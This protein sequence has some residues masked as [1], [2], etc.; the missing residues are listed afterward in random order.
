MCRQ[1]PFVAPLHSE[2]ASLPEWRSPIIDNTLDDAEL[3]RQCPLDDGRMASNVCYTLGVFEKLPVELLSMVYLYLDIPSL[4]TFRRVNQR[5]LLSV[6][7]LHE[8]RKVK[9]HCPNIL[10]AVISTEA[11]SY[12][13]RTLYRSLRSKTCV[14]CGRFGGYL[15]LLTSVRVCYSC[16]TQSRS[17]RPFAG[18][19]EITQ[20]YGLSEDDVARLPQLL[21]IPGTYT[22]YQVQYTKRKRLFDADAVRS[23]SM[24]VRKEDWDSGKLYGET[25]P[26]DAKHRTQLIRDAK[27]YLAIISAPH[28]GPEDQVDWGIECPGCRDSLA[29]ATIFRVKFAQADIAEHNAQFGEIGEVRGR[30]QHVRNIET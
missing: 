28:L 6:D 27:R 21:N 17:F 1:S 11:R 30:R 5:A 15:Y 9:D 4:M 22:P 29:D 20:Y 18:S 2:G 23:R 8:F 3:E 24:Q 16:F 25:R 14:G 7:S 19:L 13:M 26:W 12:T 10:R